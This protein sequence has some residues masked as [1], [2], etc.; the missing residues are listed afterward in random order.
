[1]NSCGVSSGRVSSAMVSSHFL[2]RYFSVYL[3]LLVHSLTVLP[4]LHWYCWLCDR[5]G[6]RSDKKPECRYVGVAKLTGSRC[7]YLHVLDFRRFSGCHYCCPLTQN[8]LT[9]WYLA[10]WGYPRILAVTRLSCLCFRRFLLNIVLLFVLCFS[11]WGQ[12]ESTL[13]TAAPHHGVQ[14]MLILQLFVW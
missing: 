5:K 6:I 2:R 9:Y 12:E 10:Y 11:P 13:L 8:G 4:S 14:S 1:V 3:R 7:K